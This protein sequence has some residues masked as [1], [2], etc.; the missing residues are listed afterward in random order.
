MALTEQQFQKAAKLINA[1]VAAVKAV[2]E[3][4]SSGTGFLKDGRPKILF[5]GHI[6]WKQLLKKAIDPK[7]KQKGNED[8]LF[9]VWDKTKYKG[10]EAE[11]IRLEKAKK[12]DESCALESASYGAFQIM[13][14]HF[15]RCGF[16]S[17]QE[18]VAAQLSEEQQLAAF[19]CFIK[20]QH[21]DVNLRHLDWAGFAL[22]YNGKGYHMN[23]YDTKLMN[24]YKKFSAIQA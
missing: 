2:N 9:P 21:L 16:N 1:E 8:I 19:I 14:Y 10:K 17:V 23:Q 5:E 4:E 12:I 3:V 20:D 22:G 24:A 15:K 11:Y 6:F 13:G 18:F 7:K